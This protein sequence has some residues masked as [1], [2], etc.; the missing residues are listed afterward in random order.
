MLVSALGSGT[1]IARTPQSGSRPAAATFMA[2]MVTDIGGINDRSFN[3]MTWL[4]MLAAHAAK[5]T[6]ITARYLPSTTTADY[7]LNIG[8]FV[9][10]NCGIIVTVGFLMANATEAAAKAHPRRKF[11]IVDCTYRSGCLSGK[12][13]KNIDQL[14]FNVVQDG[15]LGGY[16]AAG[17]SKTHVV[18]T[19]GGIQFGTVTIYMDGFW[20]GV[21]YYNSK[22]HTHVKVLGWNEK[23]QK[24]VFAGSFTNRAV[25]A[26]IAN[27]FMNE[28]ADVIFPI[29]GGT[30]L[31]TARAVR[32]ADAAGRKV[33]IE[34]D[35]V[36]GC[37]EVAQYCKFFLTTVTKGIAAEVKTIVLAANNGKFPTKYVGTLANADV[38]LAPYHHFATKVPAALTADLKK[39]EEA[40]ESGKI[41]PVTKSPV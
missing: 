14:A 37:F 34:W 41:V 7:A 22:H 20:D 24:G 29:A 9:R 16:L 4:G 3:E 28:G 1:A 23:T 31:G 21:Q 25:G 13:L 10:E 40:I 2:C 33:S 36:D 39:I 32:A 6:T 26:R 15:F 18:G 30:G 27:E 17:M 35:D 38:A 19:Y 5:P 12:R 8:V 11:A